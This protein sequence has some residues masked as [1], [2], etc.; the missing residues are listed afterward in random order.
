MVALGA[1]GL[2]VLPSCSCGIYWKEYGPSNRR[3]VLKDDTV[4]QVA[5]INGFRKKASGE[6][7]MEYRKKGFLLIHSHDGR[8]L[9][10]STSFCP[11]PWN[12]HRVRKWQPECESMDEAIVASFRNLGVRL[13]EIPSEFSIDLP[14]AEETAR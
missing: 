5:A 9:R 13:K 11:A 12:L 2:V 6:G 4:A 1:V 10:F 7:G 3:Q 8:K 14:V